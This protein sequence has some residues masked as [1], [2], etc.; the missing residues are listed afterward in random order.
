MPLLKLWRALWLS[1]IAMGEPI[2]Y[3]IRWE[4][5]PRYQYLIEIEADPDQGRYTDFS[6]AAWRP[7]RYILQNYAAAVSHFSAVDERGQPLSWRKVT[8]DRWRVHNPVRG[9]IRVQYRFYARH[10]DAGSSYLSN[11][12]VYFNPIN[13]LMYLPRR[14]ESPCEL[15]L[16]LLP[17]DWKVATAL[18]RRSDGTFYAQDYHHLADSPFLSG[19]QLKQDS[20]ICEGAR[21][22]VHFWG[23]VGAKNLQ[24]FLD[25]LCKIIQTQHRLWKTLPLSEYHF[26]YLL[27]PFQ[28]RHAVEHA[29]SAMF[30]LPEE[31]ARSEEALKSFLGISAHEFFHVWNVKRLRPA[32]L[33]PY[34]YEREA[35]TSLHWL[36]EGITDYYT[37]VTL[38]RAGI[39]SPTA[40]WENLS[41]ELSQIENTYAYELFSP[42]ELSMDSWLTTSPYRPAMYQGS[43]YAA[44]KRVGFLLDMSLRRMT[45]GK[46]TLDS[47]LRYLYQ[48]Y[49]ERGRGIP[50]DGVEKAAIRLGG[51]Y[52]KEFF[53]RYIWGH[54][55]PNYTEL[56]QSLPLR[57]EERKVLYEGLGRIGLVRTRP[58]GQGIRV[59][60]VLPQSIAAQI[61]IEPGALLLTVGPYE[62]A[63]L[64][65]T[66]WETLREGD[67]L[68][69]GWNQGDLFY[70]RAIRYEKAALSYRTE[71]R[72]N[73]TIE[74]F[75]P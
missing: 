39:L 42:A 44:G 2:R 68:F 64:P 19:P 65:E 38:A 7:G 16:P 73:P 25:D 3:T 22:F 12:L 20:F 36:T 35:Y 10:I 17:S 59:E 26:I 48:T 32:A 62:A 57:V 47:L 4:S 71:V 51:P 29:Y 69:L 67:E 33:L 49:Y 75:I 30:V 34:T 66:F 37:G 58:E 61:G 43:F 27:V 1:S 50:E 63:N 53:A 5:P 55:K 11:E 52:F 9:R 40:Y 60:E 6:L 18:P 70:D 41:A 14:V 46:V 15:R 31:G 8:K 45:G 56:L 13:L 72:L 21:F 28:M 74:G 24:P 23:K 54:E